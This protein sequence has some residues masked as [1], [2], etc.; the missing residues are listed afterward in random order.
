[1]NTKVELAAK[2]VCEQVNDEVPVSRVIAALLREWQAIFDYGENSNFLEVSVCPCQIAEALRKSACL[3][4]NSQVDFGRQDE[5]ALNDT[6]L[7]L[8][9]AARTVERDWLFEDFTAPGYWNSGGGQE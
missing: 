5:E 2:W 8:L 4:T 1:M 6:V 7:T 3:I 9:H